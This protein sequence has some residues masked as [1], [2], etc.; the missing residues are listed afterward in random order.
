MSFKSFATRSM[1]SKTINKD[2][3]STGDCS[4]IATDTTH[5]LSPLSPFEGNPCRRRS[6]LT[7]VQQSPPMTRSQLMLPCLDHDVEVVEPQ[8]SSLWTSN[9][10]KTVFVSVTLAWIFKN[11][12][13]LYAIP[14]YL[15][16]ETATVLLKWRDFVA[17]DPQMRQAR[18]HLVNHHK[19][20]M[21]ELGRTQRGGFIRRRQEAIAARMAF[22]S[23]GYVT[24][25]IEEKAVAIRQRARDEHA[26][27]MSMYISQPKSEGSG[28]SSAKP[29]ISV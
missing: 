25:Y 4:S 13:L 26:R 11:L 23:T 18:S 5:E 24:R 15:F 27:F 22:A 7:H 19:L 2:S 21:K 29:S 14:A 8:S 17:D 3:P 28:Q 6:I 9:L 16:F 12:T 1:S 20:I 10:M